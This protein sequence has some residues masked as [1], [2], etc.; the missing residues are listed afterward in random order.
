MSTHASWFKA[1]QFLVRFVAPTAVAF[2]FLRTMP[3]VEGYVAPAIG[4]VIIIGA[5]TAGRTFMVRR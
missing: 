1:W 2:V 3:Q 5:F 4:A